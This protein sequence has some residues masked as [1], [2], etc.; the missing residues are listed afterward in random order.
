MVV[1]M[2]NR[3][4]GIPFVPHGAVDMLWTNISVPVDFPVVTKEVFKLG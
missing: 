3:S 1:S 4:V 2:K